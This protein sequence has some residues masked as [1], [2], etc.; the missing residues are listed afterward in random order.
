MQ[1]AITFRR[2]RNSSVNTFIATLGVLVALAVGTLAGY[3]LK[4]QP[5]PVI[6]RLSAAPASSQPAAP[7]HDM[8]DT[9]IAQAPWHDMPVEP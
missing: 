8:P 2:F 4:A 5:T 7:F 1:A 9:P 3:V 6:A